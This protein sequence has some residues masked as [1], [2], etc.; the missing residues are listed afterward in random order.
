MGALTPK[1]RAHH[2]MNMGSNMFCLFLSL[3]LCIPNMIADNTLLR[4]LECSRGFTSPSSRE[5][6]MYKGPS[7]SLS[8]KIQG[9]LSCRMNPTNRLDDTSGKRSLVLICF[10][11][12]IPVWIIERDGGSTIQY[13]EDTPS[14]TINLSSESQ[15]AKSTTWWKTQRWVFLP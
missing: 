3:L 13:G 9:D 7:S 2:W 15:R 14:R 8:L 11:H 5:L 12:G 10:I 6:L 4:R 1:K